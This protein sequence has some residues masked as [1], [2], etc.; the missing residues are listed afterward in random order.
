MSFTE[1]LKKEE[2]MGFGPYIGPCIDTPNYQVVGA[3]S[4]QNSKSKND[5]IKKGFVG[6]KFSNSLKIKRK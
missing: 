4:D 6:H 2:S 5:K 3:C 1:W